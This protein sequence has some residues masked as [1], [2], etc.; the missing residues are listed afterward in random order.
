MLV[1]RPISEFKSVD[2]EQAYKISMKLVERY[3]GPYTITKKVNPILYETNIE[4]E[5]KR[6]H[7]IHMK[8][9]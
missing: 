5:L 8:P 9:F 4:G 1:R 2:D 6:V 7:A 3:E